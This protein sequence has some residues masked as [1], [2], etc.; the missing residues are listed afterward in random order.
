MFVI[1]GH[2]LFDII[3]IWISI[4]KWRQYKRVASIPEL[5]AYDGNPVSLIM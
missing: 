2:V 1:M 4:S 5:V 3:I